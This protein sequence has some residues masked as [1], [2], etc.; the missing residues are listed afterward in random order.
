LGRCGAPDAPAP[1]LLL[2]KLRRQFAEFLDESS[3]A[4]LRLLASLTCVG[5]RYGLPATPL[6]AFLGPSRRALSRPVPQ[7]R[8][9]PQSP[10]A[11]RAL[12]SAR[13]S[14]Q[15][16]SR[17]SSPCLAGHG[18]ST[19]VPLRVRGLPLP[20]RPAY[21]EA[22]D[23]AFGTL[24]LS[25]GEILTPL[26]A[27]HTGIRT[28]VPSTAA[29]AAASPATGRSPTRRA[30]SRARRR[31]RF[32][33]RLQPRPF[34]ALPTWTSELLRTLSRMAAS[35]PTS[36]LSPVRNDL[37]RTLSPPFGTLPDGLGSRPLDDGA[38]PPP[39]DSPVPPVDFLVCEQAV[40]PCGPLPF[41]VPYPDGSP[42]KAR[43]QA[44]S[45]RTS[46]LR[47]R[48]AFHP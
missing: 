12:P 33:G 46:Y 39:S 29:P 22:D 24:Q 36:W 27:T 11:A 9:P 41:T 40:S 10:R 3:L 26:F 14:T 34:S 45:G 30:R 38:S 35:K 21:P 13:D 19:V 18:F 47:V 16:A 44:I 28:P 6:A 25:A 1:G 5:F 37:R 31:R 2:P 48:L 15:R 7:P 23:P 43:P 17:L 20:L 8:P 4:R 32:G 42:Q